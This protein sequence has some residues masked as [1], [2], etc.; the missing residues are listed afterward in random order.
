MSV[1]S[2]RPGMACSTFSAPLASTEALS[3]V[4]R[5]P[6]EEESSQARW[7]PMAAMR[8]PLV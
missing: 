8:E 7:V 3:F 4:R 5:V 1:E 6:S 2:E